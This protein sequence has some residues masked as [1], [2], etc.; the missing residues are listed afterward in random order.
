[1]LTLRKAPLLALSCLFDPSNLGV[2]GFQLKVPFERFCY[3]CWL[4]AY[5]MLPKSLSDDPALQLSSY[6]KRLLLLMSK[7]LLRATMRFKA[8]IELKKQAYL[9][10]AVPLRFKYV[11]DQ[12]LLPSLSCGS[13]VVMNL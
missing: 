9:L 13:H 7:A 1:M 5:S 8:N 12:L 10:L 2:K 6:P 11:E 4:W 3:L